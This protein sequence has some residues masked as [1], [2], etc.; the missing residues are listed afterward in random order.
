M[1]ALLRYPTAFLALLSFTRAWNWKVSNGTDFHPCSGTVNPNQTA[2]V[3]T[4]VYNQ[5]QLARSSADRL[6]LLNDQ[7]NTDLWKFN[8]NPTLESSFASR[9]AGGLAV[10]ADRKSFPAL[11]GTGVASALGFL[12]PCGLNAFHFHP[13][14]TQL[15]TVVQGG[16]LTAGA[17]WSNAQT[18]QQFTTL[19]HTWEM[20]ALPQGTIHYVFNDNCVPAITSNAFSSE[21]PGI[22]NIAPSTFKFNA[23]V[24]NGT[25]GYPSQLNGMSPSEF[26]ESIPPS[27]VLGSQ[28]CLDRCGIDFTTAAFN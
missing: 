14:A 1:L 3:T 27:Y 6:T 15:V 20:I 25:L 18:H 16:P 22:L 26:L 2:D 11:I 8:F 13:R 23:D 28:A 4:D 17:L 21:D 7:N 9:G 24:L 12:E 19:V 10:L 5:L